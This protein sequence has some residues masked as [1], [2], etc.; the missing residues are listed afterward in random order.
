MV[1][2]CGVFARE[3]H[4]AMIERCSNVHGSVSSTDKLAC[5]QVLACLLAYS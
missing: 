1:L 5:L 2:G 3:Q 4:I